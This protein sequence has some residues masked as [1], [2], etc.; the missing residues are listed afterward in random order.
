MGTKAALAV[1][2]LVAV[3]YAGG[4]AARGDWLPGA[5]GGV[6]AGVLTVLVLRE[7]AARQRRRR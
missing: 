1:G 2:V 4:M 6:L 7:V 5:V 3:L